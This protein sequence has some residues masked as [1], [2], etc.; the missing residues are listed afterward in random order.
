MSKYTI[1]YDNMADVLYIIVKKA[2]ATQ[3]ILDDDYIAIRTIDNDLCGLTIDG[4]KDRHDD[5]S[6][7]DIFITK[8][9]ADFNLDELPKIN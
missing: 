1:S 6:W 2:K 3:T 7:K 9:I 5:N 8:Y 4:F